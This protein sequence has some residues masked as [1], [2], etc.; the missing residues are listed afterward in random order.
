MPYETNPVY[1]A[2]IARRSIRHFDEVRS[3]ESEKIHL[4]L[5]AAMAAPSA[6]N[7][8]PWEF[9]VVTEPQLVEQ[10][11]KTTANHGNYNANTM[12][13]IC[14]SNEHIP[15]KDG[16]VADCAMAAENMMILAPAL[17]LGTVVI[18]GFDRRAIK[19]MFDLPEDIEANFIL[20]LGYP[21]G[22]KEPRTRFLEE[23]VHWN[24]FDAERPREPRPGNVLVFGGKASL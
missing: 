10:V 4:L 2:I 12:V 21:N 5:Q 3:I 16:G 15:W 19:E 6:C 13:I 22:E 24:H 18:G 17:G 14:G 23:A 20:Y 9:I 8:Q 1:E 11:K 7:I